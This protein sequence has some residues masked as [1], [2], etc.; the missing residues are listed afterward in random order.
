VE[1]E[2]DLGTTIHKRFAEWGG[3]E[4]QIPPRHKSHRPIPTFD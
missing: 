2:E 1:L 4:L 3:V